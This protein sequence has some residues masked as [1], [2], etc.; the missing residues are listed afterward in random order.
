MFFS[1][2]TQWILSTT[3]LV[4]SLVLVGCQPIQAQSDSDVSQTN[5]TELLPV[6]DKKSQDYLMAGIQKALSEDYVGAIESYD[7]AIQLTSSN[8]EVYYN[9]G[10]AYFSIGQRDNAIKDFNHAIELNPTMAEA[11]GNRGTIRLLM[12]ER[13][14]ALSD[15]KKAAQLFDEQEDHHS[16]EMIRGLIEEN[17]TQL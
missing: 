14:G 6:R 3:F 13:Q 7:L 4:N 2:P 15:F 10:V 9:R 11:Y 5:S 17:S 8:S 16:A 1:R 12:N